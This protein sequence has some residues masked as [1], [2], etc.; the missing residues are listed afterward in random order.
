MNDD[1]RTNIFDVV[2]TD[3]HQS[4]ISKFTTGTRQTSDDESEV[5]EESRCRVS[6]RAQMMLGFRKC[7]GE[8]EV[9]PYSMLT[10]IRSEDTS[11]RMQLTFT[12]GEVIIEGEQLTRLFHYLCEHRVLEI[13]ES[14][15]TDCLAS[16]NEMV[17]SAITMKFGE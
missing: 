4:A 15:R 6:R 8:I 7:N 16:Q 1:R 13:A 3:T 17:V 11:L 14:D 2:E 10:R 12:H 5:I 9:L